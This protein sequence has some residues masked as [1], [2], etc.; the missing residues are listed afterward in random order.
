MSTSSI[1]RS[2]ALASLAPEIAS[3]MV[4]VAG[5]IALVIGDDG[6]ISNVAEGSLPLEGQGAPWVGLSWA[7]IVSEETRAKAD[8]LLNEAREHG[9][10]RRREL[11]HPAAQG[12][13]IPVSWAAVRL[14][15]NGPLLA[16]GRDLRAVAAI[17]QRFIEAQRDLERD[18]WQRREADTHYRTLFHVAT[19][20]VLVLDGDT[21][22]VLEA[23]P[24]AALL[25]DRTVAE[26]TGAILSPLIDETLR[27]ALDELLI[28]ARVSGHAAERRLRVAWSEAPIDVSATPF[29]VDKRRCLLLRSRRVES[30]GSDGQAALHFVAQTPDAVVVT[31]AHGRVLWTNPAFAE[32]CQSPDKSRLK[33]RTIADA[34]GGS[35]P[36]WTA[37]LTR[38][39][40]RGIVG[41]VALALRAPGS[42]PL[43]V[44]VSAA[45]LAEGDQEHIGFT[46]RVGESQRTPSDLAHDLAADVASMSARLG[47][48]ALPDLLAEASR[49]VES[50]LL[51][52]ALQNSAGRIDGAADILRISVE[53]F[54][55]R[56]DQLGLPLLSPH[57][58]GG[59]PPPVN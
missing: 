3:T 22:E 23:N 55:R 58:S 9:V 33:G 30:A 48:S 42:S 35:E 50:H 28:T 40:A 5:D 46:L 52:A 12:G 4:R 21:L 24:A 2:Q 11:N 36:Q 29:R 32:L 26:L 17:Q 38:V 25:F 57:G 41:S 53:Q 10:S 39:R 51:Q 7:D 15:D 49:T 31:D 56:M 54:V 8:M 16:V 59:F 37:L 19:D 34:L 43:V 20:A 18:Y 47:Q 14:G 27:A 1:T 13:T 44:D 45:L 6:V